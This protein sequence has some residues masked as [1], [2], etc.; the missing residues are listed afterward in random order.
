MT[1][2]YTQVTAVLIAVTVFV[3]GN[4]LLLMLIPLS[5][6]QHGFSEIS[7]GMIGSA[8]FGGM[9]IGCA[10][11][12][13]IIG[14]TGHIRAFSAFASGATIAALL[15]P[16]FLHPIAW[17][18]L[19][20]AMG[21]CVAGMYATLEG[22]IQDKAENLTRGRLMATYAV[23][24]YI[25][26]ITG[27]QAIRLAAP[28]EFILFSLAAAWIAASVLPLAFSRSDPPAPPPSPRLRLLWLYRISPVAVTSAVVSGATSGTLWSLVPAYAAQ[29]GFSAGQ[30]ATIT[31][32][33]TL[34]AA[35]AQ[36]PV[37]RISDKI[38]RRLVLIA[39]MGLS[40][41]LQAALIL[42]RPTDSWTICLLMLPIGSF[43]LTTY[44][45]GSSHA[46][47]K[48][49]RENMVEV[50]SG[51][52][53]LYTAG[54]ICAPTISAAMMKW[55]FPEALFLHNAVLQAILLIFVAWRVVAR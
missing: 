46:G 12:P 54:A 37:G 1:N 17:I 33:L 39:T 22:W 38:D 28:T 41:I 5:G 20:I 2:S 51:M 18:L 23:V 36:W 4:G 10:L 52:L 40:V 53:L 9:F 47:D 24:Q 13:R 29:H 14:R 45:L 43:T 7:I 19:R 50:A 8:F 30:N 55:M 11:C 3:V 32:V 26:Q 34:G 44:L 25:G 48:A 21:I 16:V 31:S 6:V 49:G 42:W 15:F 35:I 27:Q